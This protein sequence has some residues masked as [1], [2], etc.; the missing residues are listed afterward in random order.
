MK[1]LSGQAV[2]PD[3]GLVMR[4]WCI[5]NHLLTGGMLYPAAHL[6]SHISSFPL[7]GFLASLVFTAALPQRPFCL[8][9]ST[10]SVKCLQELK[11]VGSKPA[12]TRELV[13]W[14]MTRSWSR[15]S[16]LSSCCCQRQH[17]PI[18][19]VPSLLW[20]ITIYKGCQKYQYLNTDSIQYLHTRVQNYRS[21]TKNL[22]YYQIFNPRLLRNE[23]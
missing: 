11:M 22:V 9:S 2:T 16:N 6:H 1:P 19:S 17:P 15:K 5:S 8:L 7:P 20:H 3:K 21:Y 10:F 14:K 13:Q 4:I 18:A 23:P 12:C